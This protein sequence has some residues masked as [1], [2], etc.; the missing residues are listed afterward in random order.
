[1][2]ESVAA[3]GCACGTT[4]SY[5]V[6]VI[7][8]PVEHGAPAPPVETIEPQPAAEAG[9]QAGVLKL[10]VPASAKVFINGNPTKSEGSTR[11]FVSK[12]LSPGMRYRYQVRAEMTRDG[13]VVEQTKYV[14][15]R[16]GKTAALAFDFGDNKAVETSLTLNVPADAKVTLSGNET[17]AEG[18]VRRFRTQKIAEGMKWSD[19]RIEVVV[20]REGK[21][22]T[23]HQDVTIS[24]GDQLELT[25]D[26][27]E[28]KLADAR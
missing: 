3:S 21:K 9:D 18:P 6:E 2:V 22:L 12:G 16:A 5:G 28:V 20:E 10:N 13:K 25:F 7:G 19:Y 1:V 8:T 4:T 14:S 24:G 17:K 23:K 27:N 26:F 15:L 11:S